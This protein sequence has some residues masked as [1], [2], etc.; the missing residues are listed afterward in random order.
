MNANKNDNE[1]QTVD[2]VD[3]WVMPSIEDAR[4]LPYPAMDAFQQ[5]KKK[6]RQP[7]FA[8]TADLDYVLCK[9]KLLPIKSQSIIQME[10]QQLQQQK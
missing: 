6:S 7:Q 1:R 9:P 3:G 5:S 4:I 10:Q 8:T 2:M